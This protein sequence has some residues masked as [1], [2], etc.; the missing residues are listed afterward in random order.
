MVSKK[1]VYRLMKKYNDHVRE[2][3]NIESLL[4]RFDPNNEGALEHHDALDLISVIQLLA[5]APQ[6]APLG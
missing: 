1:D 3:V 2:N 5:S 6:L 4:S